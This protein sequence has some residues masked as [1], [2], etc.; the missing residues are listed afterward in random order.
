MKGRRASGPATGA[1]LPEHQIAPTLQRGIEFQ[2]AKKFREAE[3]CYQL[4]LRDYPHQPEALN[5]MGTLA[6]HAKRYSLSIELLE[7]AV[8]AKP[9]NAIYR[10]NLANSYV[11]ADEPAKALPH[12]RKAIS[13]RPR[14]IE[15]LLNL[16]RTNRE[17]GKAEEAMKAFRKVLSF[18]PENRQAKSGLGDTCIDLGRMDEATMLFRELLDGDARDVNAM[19][20]LAAAHK[21]SSDDPEIEM[22]AAA[23]D[24][25]ELSEDGRAAIHDSLGKAYSDLERYDEAFGHYVEAKRITGAGYSIDDY[26]T[27][28]DKTIGHFTAEFFAARPEFGDQT[29]RPVFVIGMPRS[30][31]TLT[32]QILASH[33]DVVGAGELVAIDETLQRVTDSAPRETDG[34]FEK[35]SALS[36]KQIEDEAG[37]YLSILKKHSFS[38]LRV[39]DKMPHNFQALGLIALMFP[40]ARVIH[41]RRDPMDT[42]VSCFTHHFNEAHG[43]SRDLRTLGLY[44]REYDRLVRHWTETLDLKIFELNYEDMIADQE[45]MSRALIGFLELDWDD[46]CLAFH[47]TKRSVRTLSRW[48]VRQPIYTT[49]VK[50]WKRYDAHLGPLKEALGDLYKE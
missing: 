13:I 18:D 9:K 20:G 50:R 39:V 25:P 38:A 34:Y 14:F 41:C 28:I 48:Q 44:Y 42:C 30:G 4:V 33:P 24:D 3:Y 8:K 43:Y 26:R 19:V 49:S 15:A 12:L 29:N 6:V 46:A 22:F 36:G 17:V 27:Y 32:E 5:L 35:I 23:L 1:K 37:N 31:T 7:K 11:M 2:R 21:F 16:A 40:N 45:G 10:N 47:E